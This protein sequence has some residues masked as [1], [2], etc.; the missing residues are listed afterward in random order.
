MSQRWYAN[1][2]SP[3]YTPAAWQGGWNATTT[4]IV[5][6]DPAKFGLSNTSVSLAETTATSPW[7][8]GLLRIVSRPLA[9]Q[10]ISGT[11]QVCFGVSENSATA[12]MFWR[13]H[14]YVINAD[15]G[16][17]LGTLL[18]MYE[19]SSG[20]G[21]T[22]WPTTNTG[23][24][25]QAAQTLTN[26]TIPNDGANYVMV[27]EMG[28]IAYNTVTTSF[29]GVMRYGTITTG[30]SELAD[31]TA[32]LT[33]TST[34][35]AWLEFSNTISLAAALPTN[36]SATA[37][38]DLGTLPFSGSANAR[39]LNVTNTL[40][41]KYT[42]AASQFISFWPFGGVA[43]LTYEPGWLVATGTPSSLTVNNVLGSTN[44]PGQLWVTASTTYY[45]KVSPASETV[46]PANL[47]LSAVVHADAT[48]AL[49]DLVIPD[50][51]INTAVVVRIT[52]ADYTIVRAINPFAAGEAGDSSPISQTLLVNNASDNTLHLYNYAD[53]SFTQLASLSL[54]VN[55]G[56]GSIR[57]NN[58]TDTYWVAQQGTPNV[59]TVTSA[60]AFGATTYTLSAVAA[61]LAAS[62]DETV[63]YWAQH[64]SGVIHR[65]DLVNKIALSDLATAAQPIIDILVL[66]DDSIVVM[67]SSSGTLVSQVIQYNAAGT[68]LSTYTLPGVENFPSST[69]PRIAYA[70]NDPT[71]I[72]LWRHPGDSTPSTGLS[73]WQRLR[74][75]DSTI[76]ATRN[77]IEFELSAYQPPETDTPLSR[78][79]NS[80]SCP[81]FALRSVS[82]TGT[83]IVTKDAGADTTTQFPMT[84]GG[85][86]SPTSFSLAGGQSTTYSGV[87]PGSG[88]TID[89]NLP[90]P[91]GWQSPPG[92]SVSNGSS[93]DNIS[94]AAGET[95][96]VT[97]TNTQ[98]PG[99]R[100]NPRTDGLPYSPVVVAPCAGTGQRGA[101]RTGV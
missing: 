87:T 78:F 63:L 96:T 35:S 75:S 34:H 79:G 28:T 6:M 12:D 33:T 7:R 59:K 4:R 95:V 10:T 52:D 60:G 74:L 64:A 91:A 41:Y 39:A 2:D 83:I 26:V 32:G 100:G 42:P 27:A 62:N 73:R 31:L 84:A 58:K 99:T 98:C 92:Y 46:T 11:V 53:F 9:P 85:G 65:Y 13:A 44:V 89:E 49:G 94:V 36:L 71:E 101:A 48:A 24:S 45:F 56:V 17:V 86:L 97:V 88:Y 19:E 67:S 54:N 51:T 14:I 25:F 18:N 82:S 8:M 37:A 20:G 1:N 43:P 38:T 3:P 72:L 68:V 76:L 30:N 69:P 77:G 81:F 15:T 40:W 47:T 80:F 93:H 29:T 21:G 70:Q 66:S 55:S 16:T 90:V 57:A 61:S 5:A 22:E 50:D 23:K